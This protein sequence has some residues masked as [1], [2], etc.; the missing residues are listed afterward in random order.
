VVNGPMG[1][2]RQPPASWR[3]W[4]LLIFTLSVLAHVNAMFLPEPLR[5]PQWPLD[6]GTLTLLGLSLLGAG[7]GVR[8]VQRA[9]LGPSPADTIPGILGVAV[10]LVIIGAVVAWASG[11]R[12][13]S[14]K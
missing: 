6:S 12:W 9:R 3:R 10:H 4:A 13:L 5:G 14:F 7:F 1:P 11:L 2:L 8:S